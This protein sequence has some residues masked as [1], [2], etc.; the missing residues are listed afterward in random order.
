MLLRI[1][2]EICRVPGG[3]RFLTTL[4]IG[5]VSRHYSMYYGYV[6]MCARCV[7]GRVFSQNDDSP[8]VLGHASPT[9][10]RT[11]STVYSMSIFQVSAVAD[12]VL[13]NALDARSCYCKNRTRQNE[14]FMSICL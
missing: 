2:F 6:Q 1:V 14:G 5:M 4:I 8:G 10:R 9:Y 3:A 7:C 11:Q 12:I 13:H